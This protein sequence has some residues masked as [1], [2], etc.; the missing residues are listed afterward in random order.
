MNVYRF[1]AQKI[2]RKSTKKAGFTHILYLIAIT[3]IAV[4][5]SVVLLSFSVLLGFK[6]AIKS[7]VFSFSGHIRIVKTSNN[8][9]FEEPPVPTRSQIIAQRSNI[10]YIEHL[11]YY[12]QK[13]S[14]VKVKDNVQGVLLK[15]V[16]KNF[17]FSDFAANM[18]AGRWL[19]FSDKEESKELVISELISKKLNISVGDSLILI[20]VQ[21]PPR[22]RKL[23]VVGIYNSGVAMF[24][25]K[26]MLTDLRVLQKVNN[27][28]DSLVSGYE[29][30]LKNFDEIAENSKDLEQYIPFDLQQQLITV[31]HFDTFEW[32]S[33]L[34]N[35][36]VIILIV[37]LLV[38]SFNIISIVLITIMERTQMIGILKA[39]GAKNGQISRIFLW[40]GMQML[41]WGLF[42]G[43]LFTICLVLSQ[44]Y[45]RWIPLD[46]QSYFVSYVPM[47]WDFS[48][49]IVANLGVASLLV[50]V[51]TI[52]MYFSLRISPVKAIRFV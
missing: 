31:K 29:I 10:S 9:S 17:R 14:V 42:W 45:G 50:L 49:W 38:A 19:K 26:V 25:E 30:F 13:P 4:A 48:V 5:I 22:F 12:V 33:L 1:I 18:K 6:E 15:G 37:I 52:P 41:F 11:Q 28:G 21:K 23:S 39:L 24:D 34:D 43:N 2:S 32:L 16:D 27:W 51:M 47:T 35:N 8:Q 46:A 44:Y 40:Q 20:F 36:V 3:S 7:K